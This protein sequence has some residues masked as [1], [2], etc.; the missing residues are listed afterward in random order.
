VVI[1]A[2]LLAVILAEL[3]VRHVLHAAPQLELDIYRRDERGN[4]LLRPGL[5][6]RHVTRLWDVRVA[7]N[8]EG[9][10]D[11]PGPAVNE[12]E[13]WLALGDSQAFGWGVELEKT[14]LFLLEEKLRKERPA[15]IVK[16]AVPG[17]GT[18]DQ[19][20]L[21]ETVWGRYRP[22]I[23][24]LSLFVGN[25]FTDVQMGGAAQFEVSDG[26]LTRRPL[27]ASRDSWPSRLR[28]TVVRNSHLLQ[29]LRALQLNWTRPDAH[30]PSEPRHWDEW[31]R[32][33]AQVHLRNPS[34]RTR[35][36]VR[37]TLEWLDRTQSY[38][39]AR[40]TDFLLV[41]I[42][43][44]FQIYPAQREEMRAALQVPESELD[45]DQPQ[46]LLNEWGAS[47]G[48]LVVDLLPAFLRQFSM[49]PGEILYYDPDA[50]M[51]AAGHRV[52]AEVIQHELTRLSEK[53]SVRLCAE[54]RL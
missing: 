45:L 5:Q 31:L 54:P 44:S 17:T 24:V 4:L 8:E 9:W 19:Y 29:A 3:F 34:Q 25:D 27:A 20:H 30:L 48:V 40:G 21:L 28:E 53:A 18:S 10:R 2:T 38:C 32:E 50:H 37:Q 42:P 33:F 23:V 35:D 43:R 13:T 15:R 7:I 51:N 49:S 16:A 52:A 12:G 47:T 6:R 36:A 41:V 39:H 1:A 26:L 14:Y 22:Q 11:R 46:R